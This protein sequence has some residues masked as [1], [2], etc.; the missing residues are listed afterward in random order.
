[1]DCVPQY[2]LVKVNLNNGL[3]PVQS[4]PY[5]ESQSILVLVLNR[6]KVDLKGC[7]L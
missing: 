3:H 2:E 6:C 1:M 5:P 7:F 4:A